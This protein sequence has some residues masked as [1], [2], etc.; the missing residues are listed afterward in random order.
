MEGWFTNK[1]QIIQTVV[2]V[3]NL[4]W[5]AHNAYPDFM[6]NDLLSAGAIT[7]WLALGLAGVWI[8]VLLR[9]S[10]QLKPDRDTRR[11]AE[12]EFNAL[13]LS[14]KLALRLFLQDR[15]ATAQQVQTYLESLGFF[16]PRLDMFD[17]L[18]QK[19]RFM[20]SDFK[21]PNGIRAEFIPLARKLL[22]R[23]MV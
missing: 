9:P 12:A 8:T 17:V 3:F 16:G 2:V 10:W 18:K 5:T 20:D 6:K 23:P 4:F 14:E 21:G 22:K 13:S 7:F 11:L 1:G 19:T 15:R